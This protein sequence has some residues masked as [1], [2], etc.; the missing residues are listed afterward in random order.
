M[1]QLRV[2]Q[3]RT[4]IINGAPIDDDLLIRLASTSRRALSK[5]TAKAKPAGG[6]ALATYL[7]ARA[8]AADEE[9]DGDGE[10]S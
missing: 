9:D 7:A 6:D 8:E 2:E 1:L 5:I 3:L 10:E 4:D